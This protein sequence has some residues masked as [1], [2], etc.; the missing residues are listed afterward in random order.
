MRACLGCGATLFDGVDWCGLCGARIEAVEE[1]SRPAVLPRWQPPPNLV[2]DPPAKVYSRW[3]GGPLS[4]HPAAKIAVT[5]FAWLVA[6]WFAIFGGS[7]VSGI[8]LCLTA[9][10]IT[11]E[12]WK[13]RRVR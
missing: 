9:G 13:R 3:Q 7:P 6:G 10:W 4:L 5:V 8:M 2:A 1:P 11:R 12:V